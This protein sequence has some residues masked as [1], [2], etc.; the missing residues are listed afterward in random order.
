MATLNEQLAA[1]RAEK[2]GKR[3]PA[4]TE[5]MHR[6]TRELAASDILSGVPVRGDRAPLF[7]RPN[8]KG[9]TVRLRSLLREG[10]V[11]MSFFRG[12]W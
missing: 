12:R 7:A 9:E 4:W 3:D 10:P 6:A 1:M 8:L 2:D 11:V 5:V